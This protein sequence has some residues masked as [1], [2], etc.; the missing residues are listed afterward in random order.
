MFNIINRVF[1]KFIQCFAFDKFNG[2][3]FFLEK[4]H[5]GVPVNGICFFFNSFDVGNILSIDLMSY[6]M[7]KNLA[8]IMNCFLDKTYGLIRWDID[9]SHTAVIYMGIDFFHGM[10]DTVDAC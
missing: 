6:D 9:R 2:I 7:I 5:H 8:E 10:Y 1:G 4:L 3:F